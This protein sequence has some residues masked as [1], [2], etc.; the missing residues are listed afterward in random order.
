MRALTLFGLLL[1]VI[2]PVA[3]AQAQAAPSGRPVVEDYRVGPGDILAIS[4]FGLPELEASARITNSGKIH[5]P[6]VGI[7][8]VAGMSTS[9]IENTISERLV[10]AE[11]VKY[12]TVQVRV[13]DYRAQPV[14]ILGEVMV[15]GQFII[16]NDMYLTDLITLG[17]GFNEVASPVGYLYRRKLK[18]ESQSPVEAPQATQQDEAIPID[19][20]ALSSGKHPEL[21]LKLRGGDILYVP[22]APQTRYFVVGEVR[23]AGSFDMR[24]AETL[25]ASEAIARAGGP[26]RTAKLSKAI[27][28][29]QEADG[30]RVEMSADFEAILKGKK[31]DFPIKPNDI[32]FVPGS[33]I[34]TLGYGLLN[35]VPGTAGR[36]AIFY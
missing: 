28:V 31:P 18:D 7:L 16:T 5:M 15:P 22:V 9:E 1:L 27:V 30:R 11:L 21:N 17:M 12:P 35:A 8:K 13:K 34:K 26:A 25:L 2:P 36:M 20:A 33:A 32:I 29:R 24:G 6:R 10:K 14:Y 19:F 3:S 4:V 23:S